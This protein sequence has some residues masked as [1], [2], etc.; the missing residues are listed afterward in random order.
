MPELNGRVEFTVASHEVTATQGPGAFTRL[1]LFLEPAPD[2][3]WRVLWENDPEATA[4]TRDRTTCDEI[5]LTL[6]LEPDGDVEADVRAVQ[7]QVARTNAA[8]LALLDDGQSAAD[9]AQT[10][11]RS[12]PR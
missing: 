10:L 7:A 1:H 5:F 4:A 12:T 8:Y 9:V 2:Q 3:P 11:I 6:R